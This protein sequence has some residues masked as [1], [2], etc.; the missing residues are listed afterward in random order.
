[1]GV[2]SYFEFVTTL[3]GWIL[4]DNFWSV[5]ADSG[6]VYI[7]FV[8]I[9]FTNIVSSKKAGDDEGSAALQ[10]LKKSETDIILAIVVLFIAAVPFSNVTL[11]EMQ[12]VRPTLDCRVVD[13]IAAGTEQAV[14]AGNATGT[15]YQPVLATI[16]GQNGR[17]PIWWGFVHVLTKSVVAASVAS[18]PCTGDMA[19]VHMTLENE[20]LDD[21]RVNR[22]IQEFL[23]DC[24]MPSKSQFLRV[25]TTNQNAAVVDSTNYMGSDYFLNQPGYYNKFY[26][27]AVRPD[28]AFDPVRDGGFEGDQAIGGHPSCFQW[29]TDANVGLRQKILG[30]VDANIIDEYITRP[31]N[32]IQ[33]ATPANL[34]VA[35]R[36]DVFLRKF[37][38]IKNSQANIS[39]WG[40]SL[41]VSYS[42]TGQERIGQGISN[43]GFLGGLGAA[44][45]NYGKAAQD[46]L[47]TAVAGIGATIS[48][49]GHLAAGIAAREGSTIFLSLILMVFVCILPF[50]MVFSL[51]RLAN[52]MTLSII[53]FA[54]HFTY[55]LFGIAFWV[56]NNLTTAIMSGGGGAGIFTAVTNPT[57]SLIMVW[58]Q[59]FLYMVFPMFWVTALTW[60]GVRANHMMAGAATLNSGSEAPMRA[61][62]DAATA[63]ATK[64]ASKAL[65]S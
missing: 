8:I 18:I 9:L 44:L 40:N 7:P 53:F 36:E 45:S 1:M 3:F 16:G 2:S 4:Y 61:G 13:N 62:A 28:W 29:W 60:V 57:Q 24:F 47:L 63:V 5:L 23:N 34:A 12:F 46:A 31:R 27:A 14:V 25:D 55:V 30:A 41:S 48:A 17:I 15:S 32:L 65:K 50:L 38:A 64:G 21:P 10:S 37:L 54:L 58:S 51:Y 49:P 20:K 59:R 26:S 22:E 35:D 39:G 6:V 42:V 43:G 56:D 52:L 19:A 33:A 11:G